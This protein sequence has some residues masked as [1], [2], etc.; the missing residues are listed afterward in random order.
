MPPRCPLRRFWS[1]R[2]RPPVPVPLRLA[3]DCC[4]RNWRSQDRTPSAFAIRRLARPPV[5]RI[6]A[7]DRSPSPS[8]RSAP[9]LFP[10][11]RSACRRLLRPHPP[12]VRLPLTVASLV[13][14]LRHLS[15][16]SST[17]IRSCSPPHLGNF[18]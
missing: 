3:R 2:R 8:C 4:P 6:P 12:A 11:H 10:H 18:H 7:V 16:L 1:C 9:S 14:P 5:P 13:R 17:A 15:R